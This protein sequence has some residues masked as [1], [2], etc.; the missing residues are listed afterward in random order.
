MDTLSFPG[1]GLSFEL[2][3][4]AF[5]VFGRDI[6]WYGIL[7]GLA[8]ILAVAF[9]VRRVR[10][11]GLDSDRMIDVLLGTV[12][13][14]IV[15]ARLYYV[16]FSGDTYTFGR[17][18]AIREGGLAFYGGVIGAVV[19]MALMCRVRRV[20]F[21][22][23][24]DLLASSLLLAQ[25][26]GRWGNFVNVEAFGSNTGLPWGMTSAGITDY[27]SAYQ[28]Q[29]AGIGVGVDPARPVHPTFFYESIWCL[30]GFLLVS[31][32]IKRR[33]FDGEITLIYLFWYG[34]GRVWIEGLRTD[35]LLVGSVR[36]SQALAGLCVIVCAIAWVSLRK[37]AAAS[38][39]SRPLYVDTEEG[40]SV[41]D[42]SFYSQKKEEPVTAP[43]EEKDNGASPSAP[44][45]DE[46][47][48]IGITDDDTGAT[49][50]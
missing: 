39:G 26:V 32:Y 29:L 31:L 2:N 11:F 14:G 24:C 46:G 4:V 12:I 38:P 8:F 16:A 7:F 37:K 49:E 28:G 20:K 19:L 41:L 43:A 1:L 50:E 34:L 18:F 40:K 5:T 42:G 15:G 9:I 22:P 30:V 47:E 25:S 33:K 36:V 45:S 44:D 23:A 6:Y 10:T 48:A 21:L 3:R 13:G 35:S 17:L 27:L